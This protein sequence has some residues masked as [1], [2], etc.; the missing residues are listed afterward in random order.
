M[1]MSISAHF[2]FCVWDYFLKKLSQNGM[3]RTEGRT[4][5]R[6]LAIMPEMLFHGVRLFVVSFLPSF[7]H[8]APP[9]VWGLGTQ[10]RRGCVIQWE[11]RRGRG[12]FRIRAVSPQGS[13]LEHCAVSP[14]SPEWSG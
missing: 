3:T 12:T 11:E 10:V 9:L 1:Q 8:W 5:R 14:Q 13:V 7:L 6:P 4:R 2:S